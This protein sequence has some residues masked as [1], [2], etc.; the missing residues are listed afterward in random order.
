MI[1]FYYFRYCKIYLKI[2]FCFCQNIKSKKKKIHSSE[3]N[4]KHNTRS[5]CLPQIRVKID[6]DREYV[7]P[8]V[9]ISVPNL[10][11][12]LLSL[13]PLSSDE[14]QFQKEK[15]IKKLQN[16][17]TYINKISKIEISLTER[18]SSTLF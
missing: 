3:S 15:E 17:H 9:R 14:I 2:S 5:K 1:L 12:P 13:S 6:R 7:R 18:L 8:Y 11:T 16:I 10:L 4:I